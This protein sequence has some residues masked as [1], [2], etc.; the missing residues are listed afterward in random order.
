LQ[1]QLLLQCSSNTHAVQVTNCV[2]ASP[3][4]T[5]HILLPLPAAPPEPD[6]RVVS[7]AAAQQLQ[8]NRGRQT[9]K[10]S[11][12]LVKSAQQQHMLTSSAPYFYK[13][14]MEATNR[15][16]EKHHAEKLQWSSQLAED[17]A[18]WAEAC[19]FRPDPDVNGG[20]N[21]YATSS[22]AGLTGA[23]DSAMKLW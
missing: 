9:P 19:T 16:R 7:I 13:G 4:H 2:Q 17:A 8:P 10:F 22:T 21:I 5:S 23:M 11:A 15:Y 18:R 14:I 20:E 3:L 12:S 6:E 1:K